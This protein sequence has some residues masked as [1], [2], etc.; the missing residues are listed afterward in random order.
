MT[1]ICY[2]WFIKYLRE[3]KISKKVNNVKQ[4]LKIVI[5]LKYDK[6]RLIDSK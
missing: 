4:I 1:R 6:I 2:T 3:K 5:C